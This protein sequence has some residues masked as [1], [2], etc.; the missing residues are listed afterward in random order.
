MRIE[1]LQK[2]SERGAKEFAQGIE[3]G[4]LKQKV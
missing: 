2:S 3:K 4:G 1:N